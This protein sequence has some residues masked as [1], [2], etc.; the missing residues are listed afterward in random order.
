MTV[1]ITINGQSREVAADTSLADLIKTL[2]LRP[3]QVAVERNLEIVPRALYASCK[4]EQDDKLEIVT[5]VGGG[6]VD[7][8]ASDGELD[9]PLRLGSYTFRSRLFVGTGKYASFEQMRDCL[10][11]S[12]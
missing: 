9:E 2:E 12:G 11:A 6:A 7:M 8:A 5:L 1:K 10:E 4:L 3:E